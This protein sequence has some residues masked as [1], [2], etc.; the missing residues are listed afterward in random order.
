MLHSKDWLDGYMIGKE[1]IERFGIAWTEE[2]ILGADLST[3]YDCGYV[4]AIVEEL[5]RRKR[6]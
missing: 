2:T 6:A 5:E 1:D 3:D 4:W